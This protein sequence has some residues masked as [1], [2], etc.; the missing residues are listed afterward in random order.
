MVDS[1]IDSILKVPCKKKSSTGIFPA[2]KNSNKSKTTKH[3]RI[4]CYFVLCKCYVMPESMYMLQISET[5]FGNIS[6]QESLKNGLG[7]NLEKN[8]ILSSSTRL[9]ISVRGILNPSR[10]RTKLYTAWPTARYPS[11]RLIISRRC[12]TK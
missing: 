7:G 12:M 8:I 11:S 10:S 9:R 2:R 5:F 4:Q 6:D 1:E 3:V